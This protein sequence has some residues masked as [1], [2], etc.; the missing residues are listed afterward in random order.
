MKPL[1]LACLGFHLLLSGCAVP[2]ER[3]GAFGFLQEEAYRRTRSHVDPSSIGS[4]HERLVVKDAITPIARFLVGMAFVKLPPAI[5]SGL[6]TAHGRA[7]L[8]RAP[9]DNAYNRYSVTHVG[10]WR[11]CGGDALSF[12]AVFQICCASM[13]GKK[14]TVS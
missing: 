14:N 6:M 2:A 8:R 12:T 5:E 3:R 7:V 4:E 13:R 11:V 1:L 10:N 9:A